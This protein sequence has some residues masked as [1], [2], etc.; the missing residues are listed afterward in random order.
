MPQKEGTRAGGAR[1]LIPIEMLSVLRVQPRTGAF[2]FTLSMSQ[3]AGTM[4][5]GVRTNPSKVLIQTSA[6]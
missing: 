4:N 5:S 6:M 3:V 2:P 1:P